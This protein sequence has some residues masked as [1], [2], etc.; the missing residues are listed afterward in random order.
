MPRRHGSYSR[1]SKMPKESRSR[2]ERVETLYIAFT[3][4]RSRR[5][6]SRSNATDW[7]KT[8][9]ARGTLLAHI[10]QSDPYKPPGKKVS[11]YSLTAGNG[12]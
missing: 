9:M 11:V 8:A 12:R 5:P 10:N 2:A 7:M 3:F 6:D 1:I 4:A